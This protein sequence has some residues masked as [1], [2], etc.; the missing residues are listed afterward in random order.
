MA[1]AKKATILVKLLSAA[2]TG[3]FYVAKKNPRKLTTKLEFI[4]YD[5]RVRRHVLFSETKLK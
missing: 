5:P 3:W 2:G 4:K 1:P